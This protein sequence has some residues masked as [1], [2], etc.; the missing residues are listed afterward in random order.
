MAKPRWGALS[1][2]TASYRLAA[3]FDRLGLVEQDIDYDALGI[4]VLCPDLTDEEFAAGRGE[5]PPWQRALMPAV[6]DR[7]CSAG[8]NRGREQ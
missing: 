1:A 3:R 5:L 6:F 4:P 8:S 2:L 7:T